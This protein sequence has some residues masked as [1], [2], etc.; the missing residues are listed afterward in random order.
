VE[1]QLTEAMRID[2]LKRSVIILY[3]KVI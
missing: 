3:Y 2:N 1:Q